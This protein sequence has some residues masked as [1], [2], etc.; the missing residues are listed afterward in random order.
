MFI[1]SKQKEGIAESTHHMFRNSCLRL[2][3]YL[4]TVDISSWEAI[5]PETLKEFHRQD[6]HTTP[7][8]K[9]AYSF[10]IRMFLEYL[11]EIG[12]VPSALFL[13]VPSDYAPHIS[14]I[15]TLSNEDIAELYRF[16][17]NATNGYILRN[18]AMI[19]IGLRMGLR[20]SDITKIKF[21]DI[22]WDQKTISVQQQKT[23]RFLKLPMPVEVGN[24]LYR[25]ITQGRPDSFSEYIFISHRVPYQRLHRVACAT[26]L[27]KALPN[28]PHGFRITRK[29]F[30]SRMLVKNVSTD[31]IAD[32]L[33]HAD[34][35]TVMQ[36][37]S[38]NDDKMR[39]CAIPLSKIPV[40]GGALS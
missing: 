22:S 39:M 7:E 1:M 17:N 20:A 16:L 29:T 31:K 9:N 30:A 38:T 12:R 5:T 11:G 35:T 27:A 19:L 21:R 13:A 34:N 8:G 37:L 26:A 4:N 25:Y 2:L 24:A 18:A 10:K 36:Y 28:N 33:G 3:E 14:L 23:G 32:A 15:R 6:P 40:K